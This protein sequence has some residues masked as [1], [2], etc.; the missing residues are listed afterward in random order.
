VPAAI[1]ISIAVTNYIFKIKI[2]KL[3]LKIS[4]SIYNFSD[5]SDTITKEFTLGANH[6]MGSEIEARTKVLEL[7]MPKACPLARTSE[8]HS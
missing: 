3:F 2:R 5:T 8:F 6:H 4:V 1:T 7:S